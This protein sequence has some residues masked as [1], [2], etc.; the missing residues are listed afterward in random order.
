MQI[1]IIK[2]IYTSVF[3]KIFNLQTITKLH[4]N[5]LRIKGHIK[6][7]NLQTIT[8]LHSYSLWMKGLY[9]YVVLWSES[10][11]QKIVNIDLNKN[12]RIVT[13]KIIATSLLGVN[14]NVYNALKYKIFYNKE[15]FIRD[16]SHNNYGIQ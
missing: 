5:S 16:A 4:S 14:K 15:L 9:V 11:L 12:K 2:I 6:N 1:F 7:F 13:P 3:F 10:M 8:R